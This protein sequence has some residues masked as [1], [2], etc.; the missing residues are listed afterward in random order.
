MAR[1]RDYAEIVQRLRALTR[2][3]WG[4]EQV[5][6]VWGYPF[7]R[8]RRQI[9]RSAPTI[10]LTAGIH[11]EEPGSV[12]GALRWLESG[13]WAKWRVNW[14]VLPCINPYGWERNQRRNAQRRDINRQFRDTHDCP[15]AE[16]VKQLVRGR[17]FLFSVDLHEDVDAPGYYL[18]ELAHAPQFVGE[19]ILQAVAKV[20]PLN[21]DKVIDGHP[22]TGLALIR[23]D[24]RADSLSR[25][26]RWPMAY[27]LFLHCT[28]H[29]L[30]S[31]TPVRFPLNQR[32][33]AHSV[34]LGTALN[35]LVQKE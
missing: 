14:F 21:R 1:I 9:G 18:Y 23:R 34:A 4:V 31:E 33:V 11:G 30:G 19:R 2:Y 25:R 8:L 5:G 7:F 28:D 12:E 10:L 24:A 29:I 26:R 15:E 35:A 6:E 13:E 32:A 16:L 17:R 20:I 22:A 27:H 3:Q